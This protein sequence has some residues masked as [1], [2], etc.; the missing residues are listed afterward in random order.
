M[1]IPTDNTSKNTPY[2]K[3][4][5]VV[6]SPINKDSCVSGVDSSGVLSE[7]NL[8][9]NPLNANNQNAMN[10]IS[11]D[12]NFQEYSTVYPLEKLDT[13]TRVSDVREVRS[14]IGS[15]VS[16]FAGFSS[17]NSQVVSMI[18]NGTTTANVMTPPFMSSVPMN[19]QYD[20]QN[21]TQHPSSSLRSSYPI[22]T[23]T[24]SSERGNYI[25][26]SHSNGNLAENPLK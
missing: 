2:D 6:L 24:F 16:A 11:N 21:S 17:T 3:R 22:R 7:G 9:T 15:N 13:E 19:G 23:S 5:D 1:S 18:D 26:T 12:D 20:R 8:E 14:G 10:E 25:R 4:H